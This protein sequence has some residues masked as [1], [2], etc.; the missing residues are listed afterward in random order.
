MANMHGKLVG[1]YNGVKYKYNALT[2]KWY[3]QTGVRA[4]WNEVNPRFD[5]ALVKELT[6]EFYPDKFN[7]L[8]EPVSSGSLTFGSSETAVYARYPDYKGN[9]IGRET[10]YVLFQFM[11]YTPPFKDSGDSISILGGYNKSI[12]DGTPKDIQLKN[13]KVAGII[14]PMPQDLSTEQ[15]Q[16]WNGKKFTRLGASAI[17]AAGGDF[18]KLATNLSNSGLEA[19]LDA[20]KT[21]ALNRIPGVGGNLSINDIAGSTRGVV[22]NP[23]AELLYDSPDLREIGMVFKMVPQS[24]TEAKQIK[25]ICDAF[26]TASLP[27]YGSEDA[28]INIQAQGSDGITR[29]LPEGGSNWIRVPNLCK[30]TFMTGGTA[31][32]NIAQYKPCAITGVQVNYTPDGT[33]ATHSDGSPVATEI[34]LKFVETKLIFSSEIQAGF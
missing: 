16:N 10:D 24:E 31:N 1:E 9:P 23:N 28:T 5:A 26:R 12:K 7:N 32:T 33:Y 21:S 19:A 30:F 17:R 25:M 14:L 15:K 22:L 3:G 11:E 2:N 29:T 20:L 8:V 13:A 4:G 27:S 18:S 6:L 34:T